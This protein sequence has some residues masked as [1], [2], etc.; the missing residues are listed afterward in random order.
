MSDGGRE[1][2]GFLTESSLLPK[3]ARKISGVNSSSLFSLKTLVTDAQRDLKQGTYARKRGR[4]DPLEGQNYG[5]RER[6]KKDKRDTKREGKGGRGGSGGG[7]GSR[8]RAPQPAPTGRRPRRWSWWRPPLPQEQG[9][10]ARPAPR[11]GRG[12]GRE[13]P[14]RSNSRRAGC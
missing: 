13:A 12:A 4:A 14:G 10:G 7:G 9:A 8:S 11:C 6:S 2:M 1:T 5:V 3:P